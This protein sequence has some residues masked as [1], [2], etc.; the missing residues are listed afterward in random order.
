[1]SDQSGTISKGDKEKIVA[2]LN[3]KA[4][5]HHCPSCGKNNWTIGNDLI[6]MMPFSGG[7][8]IIGGPTYPAA[9]LVCN[10][11]AYIRQYMAIPMGLLQANL[12]RGGGDH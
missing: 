2:W 5:M 4:T 12:T 10:H 9:F 11:C 6:N 3:E 8:V 1:M 7:D